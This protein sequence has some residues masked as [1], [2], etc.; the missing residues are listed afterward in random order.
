MIRFWTR[1]SR[2]IAAVIYQVRAAT[3]RTL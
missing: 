3:R 1:L 2:F